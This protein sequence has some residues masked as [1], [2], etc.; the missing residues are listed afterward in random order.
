MTGEF[1]IAIHALVLLHRKQ[2]IICSDLLSKSVCTNPARVRKVLAKLKAAKLV[3]AKEGPE[4]GYFMVLPAEDIALS[5]VLEALHVELISSNYGTADTEDVKC[6]VA[7]GMADVM[8]TLR[9]E[10]N[11][12]CTEHL[13]TVTIA[14]IDAQ[15]PRSL[16]SLKDANE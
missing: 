3:G 7:S 12:R 4:G 5:Q 13:K 9:C 1:G 10:L 14:D 8:D 15:I 6:V 11:A 16:R 2:T